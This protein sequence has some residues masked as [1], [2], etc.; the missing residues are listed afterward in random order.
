MAAGGGSRTRPK[1]ET[2]F[3]TDIPPN[4]DPKVFLRL[5]LFLDD[6]LSSLVE[7]S[8]GFP[9]AG[10]LYLGLMVLGPWAGD[11]GNGKKFLR[12]I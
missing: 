5:G 6:R 2:D 7:L 9:T 8:F 1:K 12:H 3:F 4:C 10:D 11:H